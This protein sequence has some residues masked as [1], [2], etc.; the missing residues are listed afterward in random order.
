M[1][2]ARSASRT[3]RP[4]RR[5]PAQSAR[6]S[7]ASALDHARARRTPGPDPPRP[8]PRP[9]GVER[10]DRVEQTQELVALA[11]P[12]D[13]DGDQPARARDPSRLAEAVEPFGRE[14]KRVE[15]GDDIEGVVGPGQVLD[16]PTADRRQRPVR[17]R[18]IMPSARR[19]RYRPARG[20]ERASSPV[21]QPMSRTV[22]DRPRSAR[23]T[24]RADRRAPSGVPESAVALHA[25]PLPAVLGLVRSRRRDRVAPLGE[26]RGRWSSASA[27]RRISSARRSSGSITASTTSSEARW[28]MSMSAEYSSRFARDER[29]ALGLV[30]DRLDLVEE[31][32][33]DRR[34]GA[35]HRDRGASAGRCS[36]RARTPGPPSRRGRRRRPCGRSPRSSA[37]SPRRRR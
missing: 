4:R 3:G 22:P 5:S 8:R 29:L 27:K 12:P 23:T 19:C 35:H 18:S 17:A 36:S 25:G 7:A 37:R 20:R 9:I 10:P 15:A 33:V 28:R 34:L 32:R 16:R 2:S 6:P 30:L 1:S 21:P 31:D 24:S 11:R 26:A 14:L 13:A